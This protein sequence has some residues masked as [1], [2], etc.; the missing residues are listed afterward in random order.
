MRAAV[1]GK[2]DDIRNRRVRSRTQRYDTND[3]RQQARRAH[4]KVLFRKRAPSAE[5]AE[6]HNRRNP[7]R[8]AGHE[9]RRR[10]R[11]QVRED[12]D[13]LGDDPRDDCEDDDEHDP[14]RPAGNSVDVP[15]DRVLEHAAVY[16]AQRDGGVDRAGD[17]DDRQRDSECDFG[18]QRARGQERWGLDVLADEGVA[19]CAGERVDADLDRAGGPDGFH[20]VLGRVHFVHEGE[21]TDG[22]TEC[23]DDVGDGDEGFREGEVFFGP[24]GP[25][26]G[27]HAAR[28]VASL[29][30]GRDDGDADGDQDGGKVDVTQNSDFGEGG[31]DGQDQEN[32]GGDGGEDNGA[33]MA[34]VDVNERDTSGQS[35]RT[36]DHNE[37]EDEGGTKEF[38]A[39]AAK[40]Q[41]PGIS[42]G[43]N[44]RILQLDLTNEVAGEDGNAAKSECEENTRKH[45]KGRV[46]LGQRKSTE[47][48]SLDNGDNRETLPAQTVEVCVTI[49]G[50]LL[51][52][53]GVPDLTLAEDLVV[54][55]VRA[56]VVLFVFG[57]FRGDL[58]GHCGSRRVS[59]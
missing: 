1:R 17:K 35:V 19:Q 27:G 28:L 18:V 20:V 3:E 51:R 32:D 59:V 22:E 53:L 56:F 25:V 2:P 10:E 38:I 44:F 34:A 4:H 50:N 5:E 43:S 42:V 16:V 45:A 54:S 39:E 29:N 37:F 31:R 30:T 11:Q 57:G 21:L 13:S 48:N 15:Q 49:F 9:K 46:C 6:P 40:K 7:E 47:S 8:E 12:G 24:G 23:E 33:D 36:D 58:L 41:A 52:S 55:H 26:D 14:R